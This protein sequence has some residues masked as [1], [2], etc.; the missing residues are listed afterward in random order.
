MLLTKDSYTLSKKHGLRNVVSYTVT[1][2][3]FKNIVTYVH[4]DNTEFTREITDTEPL[5]THIKS[6]A[7]WLDQ[8]P[9]YFI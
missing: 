6:K 5:G 8:Y 4:S 9:E 1:F 2:T 7:E 3:G